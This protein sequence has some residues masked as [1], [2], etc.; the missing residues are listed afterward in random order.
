MGK[1]KAKPTIDR[2]T[3]REREV[4]NH[5]S[6]GLVSKEIAAML[7]ISDKTVAAHMEHMRKK[8]DI[9]N[10]A[11]LVRMVV[12]DELMCI[13]SSLS[14]ELRDIK[15]ELAKW[16]RAVV[17]PPNVGQPGEVAHAE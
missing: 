14:D 6:H 3:R 5:L 17:L 11:E 7:F 10:V 9:H 1:V 8:L 13:I 2:L 15:V 4:A 16:Q 12:E